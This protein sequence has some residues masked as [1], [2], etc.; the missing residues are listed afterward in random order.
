MEMPT[1]CQKCGDI[2]DLNDGCG[3]DKWYPNTVICETC[4]IKEQKE[5]EIDEEIEELKLDITNTEWDL[6]RWKKRLKELQS[7]D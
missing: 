7:Y 6:E 4:S 1:P 3:S 2:F 5:V